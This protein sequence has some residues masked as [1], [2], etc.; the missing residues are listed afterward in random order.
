VRKPVERASGLQR[1]H[2][3]RR[4]RFTA[5]IVLLIA[6]AGCAPMNDARMV[7]IIGGTLI[8]GT[9]KAPVKDSVV[10]IAGTHVR[11][12]GVRAMVPTTARAHN[13]D[14]RGKFVVPLLVDLGRTRLASAATNEELR[15][16]LDSGTSVFGSLPAD[17]DPALLAR[18]RGSQ[19][20]FAPGLSRR[21]GEDFDRT[22]RQTRQLASAG[23]PIGVASNGDVALE[24]ELL[25][26]AGLSPMEVLVAATRGG[27]LAQ[28][29]GR[30]AGTLTAGKFANLLVLAASPLDNVRNLA[31]SE[32]TMVG[33]RWVD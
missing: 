27:A 18:L 21:R 20:V 10:V 5:A 11:D 13:I 33:G 16:L 22:A 12:T 32:R 25:S 3:C 31:R 6:L 9:G 24:L 14:A 1:R 23:V 2:L 15:N 4:D 17:I 29:R 26:D 7:S 28:R 8:D 19:V 30:E